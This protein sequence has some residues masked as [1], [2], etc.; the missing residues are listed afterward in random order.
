MPLCALPINGKNSG[1]AYHD[2]SRNLRAS[3]RTFGSRMSS[4]LQG[5]GAGSTE[6]AGR[7]ASGQN[8]AQ[9]VEKPRPGRL[10]ALVPTRVT[11]LTGGGDKPYAYGLASELICKGIF[12][13]LI[14]SDDL[15]FPEFHGKPVVNFLNLRG[16]QSPDASIQKKIRR[17]LVYYLRLLLYV[18]SSQTKI[19]HILWNNK[20][21][22][23]D[24]TFLMLYYRLL[25]KRIVLTVHNVNARKRDSRDSFLNRLTLSYQYRKSDHIFVHSEQMRADLL[26]EFDVESSRVTVIPFGINNAVPNT[27]LTRSEA[28]HQLDI[29]DDEKVILFFGNIAPYKGLEYLVTALQDLWARGRD[30]RLII[31]GRPKNCEEYWADLRQRIQPEVSKKRIILKE[32]YVPDQDTEIYF[33]AS[34]VLALPYRYIYQSGVLFLGYSFGLPVLA[35]DVGPLKDEIIQGETGFVFRPEDSTDLAK[36]IE[37]YFTSELFRNLVSRRQSIMDFAL[38]RHSWD[39]VGV[40]TVRIYEELLKPQPSRSTSARVPDGTSPGI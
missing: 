33:K 21:E 1:D 3:G 27:Q 8:R 14:G 29:S 9:S 13:D 34:D 7:T 17:V 5:P 37:S 40:A 10:G 4:N 2:Q 30:Y 25:R 15:D 26:S 28:R 16:D 36:V 19:F 39:I 23:F 20:F 18:S 35:A 12:L 6:V 24:R 11:L 31:A 38:E 22:Y 32:E